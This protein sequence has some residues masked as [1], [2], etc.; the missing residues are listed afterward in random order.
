MLFRSSFVRKFVHCTDDTVTQKLF[1]KVQE[2]TK[3]EVRQAQIGLNLFSVSAVE[4]RH[5]LEFHDNKIV[6]DE[7]GAKAFVK[8]QLFI[9]DWNRHLTAN[10]EIALL[11]LTPGPPRRP[12]PANLV[13]TCDERE[14]PPQ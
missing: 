2:I 7:V 10:A 8:I 14:S 11:Q 6:Y 13:P 4:L 12:I 1:A 9:T 5:R 3:P